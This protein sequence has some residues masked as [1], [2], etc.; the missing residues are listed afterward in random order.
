MVGSADL[1]AVSP[2]DFTMLHNPQWAEG[3]ATSL[4][5]GLDW[6]RRQ[7]HD[8]VVVGLGDQPGISS[9]TWELVLAA[10]KRPI[11]V[12]TYQGARRNPVRL[13]REVWGMLPT[14]GDEG[15]RSLIASRPELVED[16]A[17]EGIPFD[18]DT[19]EDLQK[20]S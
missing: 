16:V 2:S 13:G 17:C 11:A 8:E 18:I 15:A 9:T 5:V 20:W 19:V 4:A 12:A 14:S 1:Q 7:G 3:M 6:A 10:R